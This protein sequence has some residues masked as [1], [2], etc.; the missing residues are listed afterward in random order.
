MT[1][2]KRTRWGAI[3]S[4][5]PK[6]APPEDDD[7]VLHLPRATLD[8]LER[9]VAVAQ[10]AVVAQGIEVDRAVMAYNTNLKELE[11][12]RVRMA[13]RLKESGA[14]VEFVHKFPEIET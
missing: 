9:A 7:N 6:S 3:L 11:D 2:A 1:E 13:D 8:D 14:R 4:G 10:N 5:V 12:A